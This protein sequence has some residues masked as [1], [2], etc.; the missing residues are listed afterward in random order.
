MRALLQ[1]GWMF[2]ILGTAMFGCNK[3]DNAWEKPIEGSAVTVYV[4][5][6]T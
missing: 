6:M 2:L 4:P 3:T 5:G 1:S